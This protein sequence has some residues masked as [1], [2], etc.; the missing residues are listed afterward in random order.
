MGNGDWSNPS[1]STALLPTCEAAWGG[2]SGRL[3]NSTPTGRST[4][5]RAGRE[6]FAPA[7]RLAAADDGVAHQ[8][9]VAFPRSRAAFQN[10]FG[11]LR[12]TSAGGSSPLTCHCAARRRS[13]P[14]QVQESR[15]QT[16]LN[17]R[18]IR[19]QP[20]G[21]AF[22]NV[23]GCTILEKNPECPSL[24]LI[25]CEDTEFWRRP[26]NGRM[27]AASIALPPLASTI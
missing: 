13:L 8:A 6:A 18:A 21:R 22:R 14:T 20:L 4:L 25:E 15:L 24:K 23:A 2:G 7:G 26:V 12:S 3:S 1:G 27:T 9:M 17:A 5:L 11:N 19:P 10:Q 16:K